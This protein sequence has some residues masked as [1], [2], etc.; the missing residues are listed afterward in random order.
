ME[1]IPSNW[2]EDFFHGVAL[3][4]WRKAIPPEHTTAEAEFLINVL[5][6]QP[7]AHV[8]DVPC[9]N[10]RLSFELAKRG[11]RVTG[12]DISEEFIEEAQNATTALDPVAT[13]AGIDLRSRVE[14]ILGDMRT[15]EGQAVYDGAFCFGN[16]FGFMEYPEMEKFLTGVARA[17]KPGARFIVNTGMAAESLLPD[18]E[19]QSCHEIGDMSIEIKE[20]YNA[21]DS[22]VDSEYIF[23]RNGAKESHFAKHWIYTAAE[24][25]RML[26]RAGFKVLDGY[27]SLKLEPFKLGSRELFVVA[28]RSSANC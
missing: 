17:L 10:G 23:E 12:V 5:N 16:S 14:F 28:E 19:E 27:G 24:I 22:C 7:G 6:C 15:I 3:D 2:F 9:G 18:F 1:R 20:R 4:L 13:A 11:Y 8:L 25:R 21:A 26:E